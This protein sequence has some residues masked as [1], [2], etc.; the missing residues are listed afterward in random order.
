MKINENRLSDRSR[1][2]LLNVVLISRGDNS[3]T[4]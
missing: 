1:R 3:R 2:F 4:I